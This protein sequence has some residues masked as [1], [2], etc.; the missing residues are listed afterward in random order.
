MLK[1][2]DVSGWAPSEEDEKWWRGLTELERIMF[3]GV[4]M[5][6]KVWI[7][8][9]AEEWWWELPRWRRLLAQLRL[10]NIEYPT[11]PPMSRCLYDLRV[12]H[13]IPWSHWPP[14]FHLTWA[15]VVVLVAVS[16]ATLGA[17]AYLL[18]A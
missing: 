2:K 8:I 6:E 16:C 14:H 11:V 3:E 18:F 5:S 7:L 15:G 10:V 4:Y 17:A 13:G 12:N 9:K 1:A